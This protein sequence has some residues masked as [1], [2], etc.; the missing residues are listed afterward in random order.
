MTGEISQTQDL[1]EGQKAWALFGKE[2][3]KDQYWFSGMY[4]G[5]GLKEERKRA[6][7]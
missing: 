3:P 4:Q 7:G 2:V 1:Y 6:K 5:R